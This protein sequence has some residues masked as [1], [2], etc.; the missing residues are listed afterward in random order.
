MVNSRSFSPA[1]CAACGAAFGFYFF[2]HNYHNNSISLAAFYLLLM[3][4]LVPVCFF[5][6]LALFPLCINTRAA[7]IASRVSLACVAG[8]AIGISAGGNALPHLDL[9]LPAESISG[10]SGVLSEDPRIVSGGRAM[11]LLKLSG[12]SADRGLRSSARGEMALLF[13]SESA[14]RLK[15]FGRGSSIFSE[16]AIF[17]GSSGPLFIADSLHITQPAPR[18]EIFRT[19][20]RNS[21]TR[22]FE[23][24]GGN[25]GALSLALLVGIRDNLDSSLAGLY[26]DAGCSY[27]LA[28]SGMHLAII[29]GLIAFA[30]KRPLGQKAAAVAGAVLIALYCLLAGPMPSLYR[31]A[32]MYLLGVAAI[33]CFLKRDSLSVLAMAF[34]IQIVATPAAGTSISFILSYMALAGI[35]SAGEALNYIFKGKIPALLAGPLSASLGAFLLTAGI[36]SFFFAELRPSGIVTGLALVPLTT[37]FMFGSI[38]WLLLD[39]I[40]PWLSGLIRPAL[41]L[42]YALM[43]RV[44]SLGARIP[45]V[46]GGFWIILI[47]SLVLSALVVSCALWIQSARNR[48]PAFN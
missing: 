3:I 27:V 38:A 46:N 35:L 5:R 19:N 22:R 2:S 40:S 24:R 31:A 1:V 45:A 12:V 25:W 43:E 29:A 41:S 20:V 36:C 32:L 48:I 16:G 17:Q 10:I 14:A 37:V 4:P 44:V 26:R 34:I 33:L 23:A 15:E 42:L 11:A 8:L 6:V 28:L 47:V 21:L 39:F 9:G 18:L 30:L 13:P 7:R